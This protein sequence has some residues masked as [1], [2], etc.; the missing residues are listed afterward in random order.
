MQLSEVKALGLIIA[1][2]DLVIKMYPSEVHG[3]QPKG[4]RRIVAQQ[5]IKPQSRQILFHRSQEFYAT[6]NRYPMSFLARVKIPFMHHPS[7][8][9]KEKQIYVRYLYAQQ[10]WRWYMRTEEGHKPNRNAAK[11]WGIIR[12]DAYDYLKSNPL[13]R[14]VL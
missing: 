9:R 2:R 7:V 12:G 10:R 6:L 8:T 11:P 3:Y 5:N 4:V 14:E 13:I 1:D